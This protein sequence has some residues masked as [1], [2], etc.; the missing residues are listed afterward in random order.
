LAI[1]CAAW[2]LPATLLAFILVLLSSQ[3]L[4]A[5]LP[6]GTFI[7]YTPIPLSQI[8]TSEVG[9]PA[10]VAVQEGTFSGTSNWN[11]DVS[12]SSTLS[13]NTYTPTVASR[14]GVQLWQYQYKNN[15]QDPSSFTISYSI[16]S[17]TKVLNKFSD[18]ATSTSLIGVTISNQYLNFS[19]KRT[20]YGAVDLLIDVSSATL[21][22][23][24]SGTITTTILYL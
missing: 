17:E 3:P 5:A 7:F 8:T 16:M 4:Q 2:F 24:Y 10:S 22:G 20:V 11:S 13:M 23:A 1:V 18:T 14:I 19:G 15:H 12:S 21:S 9:L 6:I